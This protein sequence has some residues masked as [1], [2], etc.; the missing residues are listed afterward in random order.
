MQDLGSSIK[1]MVKIPFSRNFLVYKLE[2][3]C[4]Q[5]KLRDVEFDYVPFSL[6]GGTGVDA[7]NFLLKLVSICH[8]TTLK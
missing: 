3:S 1:R 7:F 5:C 6:R 8:L 4:W 2:L